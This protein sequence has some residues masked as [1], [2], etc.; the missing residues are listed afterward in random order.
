M[1]DGD[2]DDDADDPC[3][4]PDADDDVDDDPVALPHMNVSVVVDVVDDDE[5]VVAVIQ[6][7]TW[8]NDETR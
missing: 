1:S 2:A 6:N 7:H 8:E 4:C 3:V 5:D